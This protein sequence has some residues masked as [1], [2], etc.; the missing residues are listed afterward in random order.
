METKTCTKCGGCKPVEEFARNKKKQSGI[1]CWCKQCHRDSTARYAKENREKVLSATRAWRAANR[2]HRATYKRA[3]RTPKDAQTTRDW[4]GLHPESVR[5]SEKRSRDRLATHYVAAKL[6]RQGADAS[7]DY[8]IQLKREQ[9]ILRRLAKEL[10][11]AAN[12]AKE[13]P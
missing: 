13:K 5:A 1:D 2:E 10:Q 3:H 7:P 8:L 6:R 4:K 11:G 12:Q 9:L